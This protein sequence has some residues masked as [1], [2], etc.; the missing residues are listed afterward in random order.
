[1]N[2]EVNQGERVQVDPFC[3]HIESGHGKLKAVGEAET[4]RAK[5]Q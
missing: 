3:L 4:K 5:M 2:G 1:M